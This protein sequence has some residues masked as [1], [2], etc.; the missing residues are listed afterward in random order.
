MYKLL[1]D[2]PQK[3]NDYC[4][5]VFTTRKYTKLYLIRKQICKNNNCN[6]Y[7]PWN[8]LTRNIAK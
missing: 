8:N 3:E 7:I 1:N 5:V 6:K 4:C 2:A